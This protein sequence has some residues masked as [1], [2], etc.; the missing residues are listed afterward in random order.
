[1]AKKKAKASSTKRARVSKKK[2][3]RKT[4]AKKKMTKKK[5]AKKKVA[6]KKVTRKKTVARIAK[7]GARKKVA[8]TAKKTTRQKGARPAAKK[9]VRKKVVK[10]PKV[11]PSAKA[12]TRKA[13][14]KTRAKPKRPR[15]TRRATPQVRLVRPP[16]VDVQP[17]T[18]QEPPALTPKELPPAKPAPGE[19]VDEVAKAPPPIEA[20]LVDVPA[21]AAPRPAPDVGD[22]APEFELPDETGQLHTLA[23]YR[24]RKVV[25][26][27][28]P[29]DD[30][31]G[32]TTEACGFRDTLGEFD[33]RNA[34]VLGVS[35]DAMESHRRFAYKFGLTFPLLADEDHAAAERYGVWVEKSE[36]GRTYMGVARTTFV[37]DPDGRIAHVFRDVRPEQHAQEVLRHLAL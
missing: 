34:V 23:Q 26:Y 29:K 2:A 3:A 10:T 9:S 31:P 1:M 17:L 25:L 21:A 37:I 27:F 36:Y 32:C 6:K 7:K 16:V 20:E 11:K 14:P 33:D 8:R 18:P 35:A 19:V 4:M 5:A 30:T 22:L 28:Y 13:T 12:T 15:R 24:G